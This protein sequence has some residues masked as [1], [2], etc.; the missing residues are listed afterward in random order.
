[1]QKE[2]TLFIFATALS[3]ILI[4]KKIIYIIFLVISPE[5]TF[6][7]TASDYFPMQ[8]GY[9]W[10]YELTPLDSLNNRV[11]SLTFYG[12]DSFF[13]ETTFNGRDAKILLTKTGALNTI[14]YQPF[15]DSL[16]FSFS[17][18]NGYEYFDPNLLSGLIGNLDST[19]GVNFFSFFNS[20]EGWY[21]YYRFA[22]PVNQ[23]YT[24]FSKDTIIAINSINFP[25]RFQL[26][27]KRLSDE[28]INTE[29]GSF[30]CKKFLLERRL[31]YTQL[32]PII[33]K[34]FGV[35]ET[36]WLAPSKWKVRSY[37]PATHINLSLI[38]GPVFTISGLETNIKDQITDVDDNYNQPLKFEL[39]Q[40]YPNP[41]NPSTIIKY[42]LMN[43]EFVSLK[44]FDILGSEVKILVN[45]IKPAGIHEVVFNAANNLASGIYFYELKISGQVNSRKMALIR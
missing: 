7:Q 43:S 14:N 10:N 22:N 25:V 36:I 27:G 3:R 29:I 32:I 4:M 11:D 20:L 9:K 19:L 42:S 38:N 35:E 31:S 26:I 33:V 17:G 45:E 2:V 16:F 15:I 18:S 41:F 28:T 44:I 23:E 34:L 24:I 21:S 6:G 39:Y 30:T 37:I 1:M 12:I 40:N 13:V 8:T 5:F